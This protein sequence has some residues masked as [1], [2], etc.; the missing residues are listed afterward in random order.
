MQ[1][2]K[3][4]Y[5]DK[6]TALADLIS[7]GV[8]TENLSFGQGVQA[9]V[10]IGKIVKAPGEYDDQGNVIVEPIYYDG[11]FYDVM[12]IEII[13]FEANE[14]FP[15]NCVHSFAGYPQDADG[16]VDESLT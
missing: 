6:E 13:N 5:T 8:Y 4:Q 15:T 9:V 11:Y 3:L 7:K 10:E 2:Y 1:I 16:Y 14:I 12:T